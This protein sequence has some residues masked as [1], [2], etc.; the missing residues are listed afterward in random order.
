MIQLQYIP[1]PVL[2]FLFIFVA[3]AEI[4]YRIGNI[5]SRYFMQEPEIV[6]D[7]PHRLQK[8]RL[9][10]VAV[11]VKDAD[12]YPATIHKVTCRIKFPH[13]FSIQ[14]Q[15]NQSVNSK[16]WTICQDINLPDDISG[17]LYVDIIIDYECRGKHK[18][19]LND[20]YKLTSHRPFKVFIDQQPLPC[21]KG[22][23]L[24]DLHT[25]SFSSNDQVEFGA[26][27][28][29]SRKMAKAMGL[30][31]FAVTDHSYDL[32]DDP[33]NYLVN[34]PALPKWKEL[35]NTVA[36][37]NEQDKQFIIIPGEEASIGNCKSRTVHCL[38]LNNPDFFPGSGDSAERWLQN[39]PEHSIAE[40][41]S[42]KRPCSAVLAAHPFIPVP[43]LQRALIRRDK[44]HQQDLDQEQLDGLQLWNG[45]DDYFSTNGVQ[46]WI[47]LLLKGKR[48]GLFAGTDAHGNFNRFRQIGLPH[49]SMKENAKQ[50]FGCVR[51]GLF[52]GNNFS[53]KQTINAIRGHHAFVSN[54]PFARL[55]FIADNTQFICGEQCKFKAGNVQIHCKSSAA[56]GTLETVELIVGDCDLQTENIHPIKL[57]R[58]CYTKNVSLDMAELPAKGYLRLKVVT[59]TEFSAYTNPIYLT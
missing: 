37:L 59:E 12:R 40:C 34:D 39:H 30:D 17:S 36:K 24:G 22:W 25:H 27:P 5:P 58:S 55:C 2:Y 8:G 53:L 21:E 6:A 7:I 16:L 29:I 13:S 9:L 32:D 23:I 19:C 52:I 47:Q 4:H 57:P 3:Y 54:G 56:F 43:F 41:L 1:D 18:Q 28:Q 48:V 46:E 31:Y 38:I 20:N 42:Q 35:W 45:D 10:P 51:T 33:D 11:L 14:W 15:I 44:W 49:F 50:I 26:T